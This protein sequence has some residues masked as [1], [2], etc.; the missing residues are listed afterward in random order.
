MILHCA[1]TSMWFIV[2]LLLNRSE[3]IDKW[4]YAY[5]KLVIHTQTKNVPNHTY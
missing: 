3:I 2:R 1:L 5:Y 4:S